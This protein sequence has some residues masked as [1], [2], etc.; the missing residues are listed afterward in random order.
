MKKQKK[1][2]LVRAQILTCITLND[3]VVFVLRR[4]QS[5]LQANEK[6]KEISSL[7]IDN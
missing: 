3:Q 4:N 2:S 6:E 1:S 7:S 5:E